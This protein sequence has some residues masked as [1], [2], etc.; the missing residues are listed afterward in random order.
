MANAYVRAIVALFFLAPAWLLA[1]PRVIS[2]SPSNTELAF[3]AG[4]TPVAVSA[5]SDYPPEAAGIEQVAS[6]Q[7]INLERIVALKPDLVLAWKEGNAE[8]QINQLSALGIHVLWIETDSV[9]N[10]ID[11]LQ[12]LAAWSPQ[13]EKTKQAVRTL[14]HDY[15]ELKTRYASAPKT[16]V[17]LQFGANPLFTSGKNSIQNEILELCGG[18]NIFAASRVPW[19]Q[20]SRE[21]VL[22]RD[23]QAIVFGGNAREI[24]KIEAYWHTQLKIPVIALN[25]D[26]FERAS[27]RIILAAKQLCSALAQ[28]NQAGK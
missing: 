21:Q 1:A 2:L 13:P 26:W 20:V 22:S 17:F 28:V 3:A 18:E 15:E 11:A 12:Q 25:S 5:F 14:Q 24:P 10:I 8:R 16:R 6:W 23:P 7:G 27:P 9:S 19:P 4:I